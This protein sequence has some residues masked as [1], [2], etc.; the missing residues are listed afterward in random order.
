MFCFLCPVSQFIH[1]CLFCLYIVEFINFEKTS[2]SIGTQMTEVYLLLTQHG[3]GTDNCQ[4]EARKFYPAPGTRERPSSYWKCNA[5]KGDDLT[6][7]V[8]PGVEVSNSACGEQ[9]KNN[10]KN[11][12]LCRGKYVKS[13]NF[14]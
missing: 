2:R 11:C 4:T 6:Q 8:F 1:N 5:F 12:H 9:K 7:T 13:E 3:L 14:P 10:P